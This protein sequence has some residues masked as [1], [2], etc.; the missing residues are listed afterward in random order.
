[1]ALEVRY[2]SDGSHEE[3]FLPAVR[4]FFQATHELVACFACP[5]KLGT[6][7][8]FLRSAYPRQI[9]ISIHNGEYSRHAMDASSM[10]A[11]H[12]RIRAFMPPGLIALTGG[13]EGII[14]ALVQV[15]MKHLFAMT[16]ANRS[17]RYNAQEQSRQYSLRKRRQTRARASTYS[18][19]RDFHPTLVQVEPDVEEAEAAAAVVAAEVVVPVVAAS[20]TAEEGTRG[21]SPL[22]EATSLC[23]ECSSDEEEASDYQQYRKQYHEDQG[24]SQASY[25]DDDDDDDDDDEDDEYDDCFSVHCHLFPDKQTLQSRATCTGLYLG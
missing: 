7:A 2:T 5:A 4:A 3:A 18:K 20:A 23:A 13:D 11:L 9:A 21:E 22:E 25:G 14:R 16:I 8:T 17:A 24:S 1:M 15:I 6:L 19:L 12:N 10:E